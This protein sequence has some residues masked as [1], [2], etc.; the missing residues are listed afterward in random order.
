MTTHLSAW[1]TYLRLGPVRPQPEQETQS[2]EGVQCTS[3]V[4]VWKR[5]ERTLVGLEAGA[6]HAIIVFASGSATTATVLQSLGPN[7]HVLSLND[8]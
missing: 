7:A 5:L 6:G 2:R 4:K 1:I 8:V 3:R